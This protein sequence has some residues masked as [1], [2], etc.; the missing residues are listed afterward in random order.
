[1]TTQKSASLVPGILPETT[2]ILLFT[3][4]GVFS[5]ELLSPKKH[6]D[7]T[8]FTVCEKEVTSEDLEKLRNGV[9]IGD[10]EV[11]APAVAEYV[12]SET[13]SGVLNEE[14]LSGD[15]NAGTEESKHYS[16]LL[17]IHEG[18]FHQVKRMMQATCNKVVSL[19]RVAFGKLKLEDL[20]LAEG[21][22]VFIEKSDI[23]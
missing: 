15:S 1:M 2:G 5:H 22:G 16:I 4:D 7:K 14:C 13:A 18:K 6:V 11:T 9:A 23:L 17:T 3:D 8:Y 21:E 20:N 10:G 12:K 19:K